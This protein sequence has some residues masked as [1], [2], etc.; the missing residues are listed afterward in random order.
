[1]EDICYICLGQATKKRPLFNTCECNAK[2]HQKCY[3]ELM[4]RAITKC[5]LCKRELGIKLCIFCKEFNEEPLDMACLRC[6]FK[7]HR[8]CLIRSVNDGYYKCSNCDEVFNGV[9]LNK[10]WSLIRCWKYIPIKYKNIIVS[11]WYLILFCWY[12]LG[13]SY[14]FV[15]R[16]I[17]GYDKDW[18]PTVAIRI[19]TIIFLLFFSWPCYCAYW[20][21]FPGQ[22]KF[23]KCY[24]CFLDCEPSSLEPG[25]TKTCLSVI[26][27]HILIVIETL[28]VGISHGLG[29]MILKFFY[30]DDTYFTAKTAFVGYL[31]IWFLIISCFFIFAIRYCFKRIIKYTINHCLI[32]R[33]SVVNV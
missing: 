19:P 10:S 28:M 23:Y 5:G 31:T 14:L 18:S 29:E 11:F 27:F 22:S 7:C 9:Q 1:M 13:L 12:V 16:S 20:F 30:Q 15:G 33:P 3:G 26:N 6:N 4:N 25:S 2:I 32:I 21:T 17:D 24:L 8:Q